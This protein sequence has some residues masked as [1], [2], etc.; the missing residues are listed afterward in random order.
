MY[1]SV[2]R[3]PNL[4]ATL[5]FISVCAHSLH[6]TVL[7]LS[8]SLLYL[9]VHA[10]AAPWINLNL[11]FNYH[12]AFA[13]CLFFVS[14]QWHLRLACG[15]GTQY[16]Q[17]RAIGIDIEN[18][19][20]NGIEQQ[21]K[22]NGPASRPQS[23]CQTRAGE[24][25]RRRRLGCGC[26]YE[27]ECDCECECE[28]DWRMCMWMR[29]LWMWMRLRLWSWTRRM[30]TTL[31]LPLAMPTLALAAAAAVSAATS[32]S[33]SSPAT[34][35][36]ALPVAD[37]TIAAAKMFSDADVAEVRHVVQRILVPCVFVIGLLGNSVS[38]YVLTR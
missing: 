38:I 16:E 15:R 25:A 19:I 22:C 33:S 28:C 34:T 14:L 27:C 31:P 2:E 10:C 13:F 5:L 9:S 12:L 21:L 4:G 32:S 35:S 26:G 8:L 37:A 1:N 3:T 30:T 23:L 20:G 18:A 6:S 24:A 17:Y 29:L 7:S 36:T 11:I